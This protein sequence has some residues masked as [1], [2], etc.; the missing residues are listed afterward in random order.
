MHKISEYFPPNLQKP[1]D[2]LEYLPVCSAA[3]LPVIE[4]PILGSF[5]IPFGANFHTLF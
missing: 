5:R 1:C 2:Y 4:N 3:T